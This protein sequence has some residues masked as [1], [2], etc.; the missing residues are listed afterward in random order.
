MSSFKGNLLVNKFANELC[1]ENSLGKIFHINSKQS[2]H[3]LMENMFLSKNL[4]NNPEFNKMTRAP[5]KSYPNTNLIELN[6]VSDEDSELISILRERR[7]R[8]TASE[9]KK[10]V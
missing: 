5:E 8:S 10:L 6:T 7:S 4:I 9:K 1:D 2:K 3:I